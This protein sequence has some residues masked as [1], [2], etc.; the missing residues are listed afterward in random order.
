MEKLNF[1]NIILYLFNKNNQ[2]IGVN[3]D[4]FTK[5]MTL[6]LLEKFISDLEGS[7]LIQKYFFVETI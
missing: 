2:L 6:S 4:F 7:L 3:S 5:K 1:M